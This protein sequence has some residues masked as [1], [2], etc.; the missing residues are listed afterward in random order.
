[1]PIFTKAH[2]YPKLKLSSKLNRNLIVKAY[3]SNREKTVDLILK[4]KVLKS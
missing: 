3:N 1:M 4:T 2:K